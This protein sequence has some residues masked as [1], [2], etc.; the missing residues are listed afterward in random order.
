MAAIISKKDEAQNGIFGRIDR[1]GQESGPGRKRRRVRGDILIVKELAVGPLSVNCFIIGCPDSRE[2]AVVDP[3]GD[4][5]QILLALADEGLT[6][7]YIINTHG[8]FD[9]VGG[10]K[11][12][13]D[14]TQAKLVLHQQDLPFLSHLT[15]SA[16]AWGFKV[17][18]S[19]EP[20]QLVEDG[21]TI[22][23]GSI[24]LMVIHTPG[25]SPGSMCLYMS[26][27]LFAGDTLFAGSIGRADL[28]GGDYNTLISSIK[29]KL[30]PLPDDTKLYSGHTPPST[31]G[32]EKKTNPFVGG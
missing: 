22:F 1:K 17:D 5:D 27:Y 15:A 28:P 29:E 18:P 16:A 13:K 31:L 7:K 30:F 23:F 12:L 19:P 32:Y 26:G 21:D 6:L 2:A 8:H 24:T 25:H 20:D 14:A 3:G 10:N 9:H 4:T 11:K